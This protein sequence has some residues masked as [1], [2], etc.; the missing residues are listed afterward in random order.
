[1]GNRQSG[2]EAST[3]TEDEHA[4]NGMHN[5][6]MEGERRIWADHMYKVRQNERIMKPI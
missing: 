2:V 4:Q 6:D 3:A 1:M 5:A